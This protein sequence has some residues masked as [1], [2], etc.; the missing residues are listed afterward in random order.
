MYKISDNILIQTLDDLLPKKITKPIESFF[1]FL[2]LRG[3]YLHIGK[4]LTLLYF[5]I[6]GGGLLTLTLF[7][8]L[9]LPSE[10]NGIGDFLAGFFSPLAFLWLVIG[11]F[12]QNKELSMNREELVISRLALEKQAEELKNSVH[13]QKEIVKLTR[14]EISNIVNSQLPLIEVSSSYNYKAGSIIPN[15]NSGYT[16]KENTIQLYMK[17][18]GKDVKNAYFELEHN[19][20]K[21]KS[22]L[23]QI[24]KD[25][26]IS[27]SMTTQE[28]MAPP[29]SLKLFFTTESLNRYFQEMTFHSKSPKDSEI[30]VDTQNMPIIEVGQVY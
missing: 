20:E 15:F 19:G 25:K 16:A 18:H 9:S 28:Y 10:L 22:D 4:K 26:N 17:N 30:Y 24:P 27:F 12:M 8:K 1:E 14:L 2:D 21:I 7:S 23:K 3:D 5:I 6:I 29:F 13:E 11:Y